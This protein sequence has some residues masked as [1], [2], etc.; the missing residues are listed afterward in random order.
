VTE[1][2]TPVRGDL[3]SCY[4][5]AIAGLLRTVGIP[6]TTVLG[7]QLFLGV[8][9]SDDGL[10]DFLHY[11]TPLVGDGQH[12]RVELRRCG[13]P[14]PEVA[15]VRIAEH[16]QRVGATVVTGATSQLDWIDTAGTEPAPHWF[17]AFPGDP[18]GE[19][20]L[21]D[22][23]FTWIDDAGEHTGFSDTLASTRVGRLAWSPLPVSPHQAS[24]ERWALGD[25]RLRPQWTG[26]KPWQWLEVRAVEQH[27]LDTELANAMLARTVEGRV[28]DSTVATHSWTV[29]SAAYALLADV[30]EDGIANP[31]TYRCNNDLWVAARNRDMVAASLPYIRADLAELGE[32]VSANLTPAWTALVR[33]MRYNSLRVA[34]GGK[35]RRRVRTEL[36]T[37]ATLEE[38]FR[39]R[40]SDVL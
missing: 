29:G 10:I 25:H 24:R 34:T 1:T 4:S 16:T 15:A 19:R 21:V 2:S 11:H 26:Q 28:T 6:D 30:L 9:H 8:H 23:R 5:T 37:I 39:A 18:S 35:P 33:A 38:Q 3:L 7:A 12:F 32:W 31:D 17:L 22:D 27:T 14:E 36:D 40:L 13:A 20:L